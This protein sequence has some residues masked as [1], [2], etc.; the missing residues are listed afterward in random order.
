M[1]QTNNLGA[2]D[3]EVKTSLRED[4]ALAFKMCDQQTAR[5]VTLERALLEAASSLETIHGQAGEGLYI[6]DMYQVRGYASSRAKVARAELNAPLEVSAPP[7]PYEFLNEN[8][9]ALMNDI[10][11]L[12]H[13]KFGDDAIE[14]TGDTSRTNPRHQ[15]GMNMLHA[16]RHITAYE[17]GVKHDHF[18]DL[19]HQLAAVSFNCMIEF[20][21]SQ[22]E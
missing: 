5:I 11:R 7:N 22:G 20:W 1:K 13:E 21:F 17:D 14:V 6:K 8:F 2:T 12:G 15:R 4:V 18:G 3:E 10:G 9:L 16:Y 19:K